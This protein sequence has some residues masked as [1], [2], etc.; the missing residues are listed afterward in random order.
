M[1]KRGA[2]VCIHSGHKRSS[3]IQAGVCTRGA[4]VFKIECAQEMQQNLSCSGKKISSSFQAGLSIRRAAV[5][6]GG[7]TSY[8]VLTN[9]CV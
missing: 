9:V 4:A 5:L 6:K 3:S 8:V 1:F 2:V 7:K